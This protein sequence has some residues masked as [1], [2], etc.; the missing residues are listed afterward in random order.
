M[1]KV[2]EMF[3]LNKYDNKVNNIKDFHHV[4]RPKCYRGI[5][6][7]LGTWPYELLN[8]TSCNMEVVNLFDL[9]NKRRDKLMQSWYRTQPS[10]ER[11]W[12]MFVW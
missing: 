11:Q 10:Y 9:Q 7:M 4:Q 1:I 6:D 3:A 8:K 12:F 2:L 5:L